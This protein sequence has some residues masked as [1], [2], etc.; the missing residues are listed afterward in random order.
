[1]NLF[2]MV[3][4]SNVNSNNNDNKKEIENKMIKMEE[5]I[6]NIFEI[7]N[8]EILKFYNNRVY[9]SKLYLNS[10]IIND[11]VMLNIE[12]IMKP[13]IENKIIY[14]FRKGPIKTIERCIEKTETDYMNQNISFPQ[15]SKLL[16]TIRCSI[17][18]Q[19][20]K[21]LFYTANYFSN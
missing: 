11:S 12:S 10:K 21:N 20:L 9:I 3:L 8:K 16:D 15:S 2:E 7:K 17:S 14:K 13:L 6:K 19:S 1:M 18:F 4:N 5:N